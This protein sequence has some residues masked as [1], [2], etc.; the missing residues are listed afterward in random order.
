MVFDIEKYNGINT[1][2]KMVCMTAEES[3][4]FRKYLDKVGRKW[5]SGDS[6]LL[7]N[8]DRKIDS[9]TALIYYFND[10]TYCAASHSR[11][12]NDYDG[13]LMFSDFVWD[14]DGSGDSIDM[15]FDEML[16]GIRN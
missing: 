9:A 16:A 14:G 1:P 7:L 2:N 13:Y 4:I 15:S 12:D 10:G 11:I 3:Q 5:H 8:Y 6:Y